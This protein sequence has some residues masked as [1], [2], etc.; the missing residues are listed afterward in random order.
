MLPAGFPR[1]AVW[2]MNI[3]VLTVVWFVAHL[4]KLAGWQMCLAY[5][6]GFLFCYF[7]YGC[8]RV[9]DMNEDYSRFPPEEREARRQRDRAVD[10]RVR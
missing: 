2:L 7:A 3:A 4:A 5:L 9:D 1:W 6:V 10:P 8:W